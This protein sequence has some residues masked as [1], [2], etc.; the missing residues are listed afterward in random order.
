VEMPDIDV[1]HELVSL[2]EA[3]TSYQADAS[4]MQH[5]TTAYQ[6]ILAI[7]VGA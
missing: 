7:K 3:Q 6:A 2:V 1:G 4:V 5:A